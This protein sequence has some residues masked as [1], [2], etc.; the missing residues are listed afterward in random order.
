[1]QTRREFLGTLGLGA[2]GAAGLA[3]AKTNGAAAAPQSTMPF[4]IQ[5]YTLRSIME[6]D[7]DGTLARVAEIGYKEVEFAG[8]YN[9]TPAQVRDVLRRNGLRS[10]SAHLPLP[11]TDDAWKATLDA[12][13]EI[14]HEWAVIPWLD[15]SQRTPA[16]FAGLPDRMNHMAQ[17]AKSAGMRL[18]Y[19]NHDFEF[20]PAPSGGGTILDSLVTRTDPS[21]VDFEMDVYWVTKAG[22]D[23]LALMAKYPGRFPLLHLKD[24]SPPPERKIVDVGTGTIDFATILRTARGHGLKHAYVENDIPT[25]PLTTARV[26]FTN[27]TKLAL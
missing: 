14:G 20:G 2:L 24:S 26:A 17:M 5:L 7:F 23:P 3:C 4:G 1:M 21:L 27:L 8:Y 15:P 6:R 12:A 16:T 25:D 11:A 18:G 22:S 9:R 10:P 13:R 19:H